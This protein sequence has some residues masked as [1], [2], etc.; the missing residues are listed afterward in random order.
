MPAPTKVD[1]AIS[2]TTLVAAGS[3][4]KVIIENTDANRLY[5]L[6]DSGTASATNFTFSLAQNENCEI[7]DYRGVIKGIWASDGSGSAMVTEFS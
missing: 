2:S 3:R 5:I 1:S 7:E 4:F 6:L